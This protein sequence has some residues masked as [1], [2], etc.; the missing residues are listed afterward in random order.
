M[1]QIRKRGHVYWVR[2]Y[3]DGRRYEESS[4]SGKHEDAVRLLRVREGDIAKGLPITPKIGRLRFEDAAKDLENDYTIYGRKSLNKLQGRLRLHLNPYFGGRRMT[5]ITTSDIRAYIADRQ[6]SQIIVRKARD[7]EHSD[8]TVERSPEVRKPVSNGE[9]NRE[10]TALKRMFRLAMQSGKLLAA[11]HVPM[12]R[13]DNVRTGFFEPEQFAAVLK[14]LPEHLRPI[15]QFAYIT[16]WRVPSEVLALQWRHVD[17]DVNEVR[18]DAGTTKN[19]D[20]RVFPLTDDLRTLLKSR[21]TE[22]DQLK[23]AGTITPWVF[24]LGGRR[25]RCF[26]REWR[27]ACTRAACPGRIPHDLRRTAVRNLVRAGVPE[28]VA[29]K[30]TGHKTRSVFERYNIVSEADYYDATL[31]LN[32]VGR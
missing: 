10:L 8:G 25:V 3:R 11:P 2:Y 30:L 27:Q 7:I 22:C 18:L 16:G 21:K 5:T 32:R 1:G 29:M 17:F 9:I 26:Y 20:G 12:L 31:K 28:R 4:R 14:H 15:F 13:E 6:A 23:L 19:D 24:Q